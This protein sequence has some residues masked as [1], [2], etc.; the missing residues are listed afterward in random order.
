MSGA[1]VFTRRS[2]RDKSVIDRMRVGDGRDAAA[3]N[4]TGTVG[5]TGKAC[6]TI[7]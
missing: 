1:I 4:G 7:T 5:G 6:A 3:A 2:G